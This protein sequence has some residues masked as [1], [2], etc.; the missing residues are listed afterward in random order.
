LDFDAGADMVERA[1][2][3]NPNYAPAYNARGLFRVWDG[4]SDTAIADFEQAMR[5]SPRDPFNFNAMSGIGLAHYNAGRH[6]EAALWTD[7]AIR[8]FPPAFFVGLPVAIVCYVGAGRLEDA[9][10]MMAE[11]LRQRPEWRRST[12]V[13][14]GWVRSQ[15]LRAAILEACIQAGLPE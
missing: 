8:A 6:P 9:K 11:C 14:P 3:S 13:A 7:K 1:I 10:K 4:G 15:E 5:L 2:R 12:Q